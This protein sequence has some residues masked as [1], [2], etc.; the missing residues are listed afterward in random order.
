LVR[1]H[2]AR[3]V[4]VRLGDKWGYID[5][6]GATAIPF[7]YP[8]AL[9]FNDGLA[10]VQIGDK[11]GFLKT[12]GSLALQPTWEKTGEFSEGLCP[13]KEDGLWGLIDTSGATVMPPKYQEMD[14]F[15]DGFVAT[16]RG[17]QSIYL[18]HKLRILWQQKE[19]CPSGSS[20]GDYKKPS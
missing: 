19:D 16:K 17:T 14:S 8:L 10:A 5:K 11:W 20:S 4:P 7:Q 18:D 9:S 15:I 1:T 2:E 6:L 3:R 12:D 13:V